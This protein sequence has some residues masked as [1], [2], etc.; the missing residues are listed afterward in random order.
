LDQRVEERTLAVHGVEALGLA[1]RQL[2][3]LGR[4][5]LQA[6]L[7]ET[8]VDLADHALGD[9]IGLDDRK[10]ALQRHWFPLRCLRAGIRPAARGRG[11]RG[12][13]CCAAK[14]PAARPVLR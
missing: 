6:G 5:D 8:G 3:V 4:N 10:G 1:A 14:W 9:G 7:L 11:W 13:R 12:P 2:L